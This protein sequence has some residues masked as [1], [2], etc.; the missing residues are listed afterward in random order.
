MCISM[1]EEEERKKKE[2]KR[3]VG[4]EVKMIDM[5]MGFVGDLCVGGRKATINR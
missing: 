5:P 3:G 4:K 2:S 1:E